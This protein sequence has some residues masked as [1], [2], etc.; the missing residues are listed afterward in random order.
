MHNIIL[1]NIHQVALQ[2]NSL[3]SCSKKRIKFIFLRWISKYLHLDIFQI[4]F[5]TVFRQFTYFDILFGLK[6]FWYIYNRD[7]ILLR[8]HIEL[9]G[10][11]LGVLKK[12]K[13][14]FVVFQLFLRKSHLFRY[15]SSFYGRTEL[16]LV[17]EGFSQLGV[18]IVG[19]GHDFIGADDESS[20]IFLV[21]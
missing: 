11:I 17:S 18:Y 12:S 10:R 2:M 9:F 19:T 8:L 20:S 1:L 5:L 13:Y 4:L 16:D 3:D 14:I 7:F 21:C 6:R 15:F